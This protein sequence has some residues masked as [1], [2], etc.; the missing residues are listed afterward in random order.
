M[1]WKNTQEEIAKA[2]AKTVSLSIETS[3]TVGGKNHSMV[4]TID[5]IQGD[6]KNVLD[7][8]FV[9]GELTELRGFHETQVLRGQQIIKDNLE[10]LKALWA[11]VK[12]ASAT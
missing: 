11:L 3:V 7:R 1:D 9:V 2:I 4:T 12:D 10:A 8:E 5:L 6:I